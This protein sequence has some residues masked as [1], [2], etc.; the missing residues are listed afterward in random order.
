M[1]FLFSCAKETARFPVSACQGE[2]SPRSGDE[3]VSGE[4]VSGFVFERFCMCVDLFDFCF[5][6]FFLCFLFLALLCSPVRS[7]G[8][9]VLC[10]ETFVCVT[11]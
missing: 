8:V 11:A 6:P 4:G 9:T 3:T 2:P 7:Q 5:L 10:F 1:V